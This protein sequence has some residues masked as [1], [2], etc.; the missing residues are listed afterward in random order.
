MAKIVF[1]ASLLE[2]IKQFL[3]LE[4]EKLN[5]RKKDL[6]E[7]DPFKDSKRTMDNAAIDADASEQF[8]HANV[9]G[10]K[11][12]IDR[13]LIQIRKALSRIKIGKYGVCDKCG[14]MIDTDRLMVFPEATECIKCEKKKEKK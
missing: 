9:E 6:E 4:E 3:H 14:Q 13:K 5:K 2:P 10:L 12:E 8:G 7:Q 1:P 11:R